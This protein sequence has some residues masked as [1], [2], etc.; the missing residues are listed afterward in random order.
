MKRLLIIYAVFS[1]WLCSMAQ[2]NYEQACEKAIKAGSDK[3][4]LE[5]M[6]SHG[7]ML[8]NTF[9]HVGPAEKI[10]ALIICLSR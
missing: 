9:Q 7:Y 4:I 10:K 2:I 3:E 1:I 5:V 6:E 8:E